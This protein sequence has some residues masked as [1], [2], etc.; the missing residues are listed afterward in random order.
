MKFPVLWSGLGC[1]TVKC[2]EILA[3]IELLY[4]PRVN[5]VF[6]HSLTARVSTYSPVFRICFLWY[7][8]C[9]DPIL[10]QLSTL[11][12]RSSFISVFLFIDSILK[13]SATINK[14]EIKDRNEEPLLTTSPHLEVVFLFGSMI[15]CN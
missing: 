14:N 13:N 12:I 10:M 15:G 1:Y 9:D 3:H 6:T 5:K 8:V 11:E 4:N 2:S 7:V